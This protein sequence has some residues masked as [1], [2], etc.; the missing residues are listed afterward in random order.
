MEGFFFIIFPSA[1]NSHRK[2]PSDPWS[3]KHIPVGWNQEPFVNY[4]KYPPAKLPAYFHV[5]LTNP[6]RLY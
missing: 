6:E 5:F 3:A 2:D 4:I 1:S